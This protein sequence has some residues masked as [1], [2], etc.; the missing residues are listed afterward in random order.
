MW[1]PVSLPRFEAA[2][3]AMFGWTLRN[4]ANHAGVV[5]LPRANA[6][7]TTWNGLTFTEAMI[8]QP[9]PMLHFFN[10]DRAFELV[11][12]IARYADNDFIAPPNAAEAPRAMP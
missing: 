5:E 11:E 6:F 12:D 4:V 9:L 2:P 1:P 7:P 8:G 3:W 10:M